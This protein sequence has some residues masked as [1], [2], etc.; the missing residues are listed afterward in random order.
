MFRFAGNFW[1]QFVFPG[2]V[3]TLFCMGNNG[4]DKTG[5]GPATPPAT[6]PTTPPAIELN[7]TSWE[8]KASPAGRRAG[9]RTAGRRP[10]AGLPEKVA[11]PKKSIFSKMAINR[12]RQGLRC[13]PTAPY[14]EKST[15]QG[16]VY[17]LIGVQER[18]EAT[19]AETGGRNFE[20]FAVQPA[21]PPAGGV[22]LGFAFVLF[23]MRW[24]L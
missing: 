10:A 21:R 11:T 14:S 22:R 17:L 15:L 24:H 9:R 5:R 4:P 16:S 2:G 18:P 1:L 3:C 7:Y 12:S 13:E 8:Y 23:S 20:N 6:R 19:S